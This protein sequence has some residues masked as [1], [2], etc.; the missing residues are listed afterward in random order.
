MLFAGVK[1]Y[2]NIP[3][4]LSYTDRKKAINCALPELPFCSEGSQDVPSNST[5]KLHKVKIF[6]SDNQTVRLNS[7]SHWCFTSE[8][9]LELV[10]DTQRL[11]AYN[12]ALD[13]TALDSFF[14]QQKQIKN[15]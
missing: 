14:A 12:S 13:K 9:W 3:P 5:L 1:F 8:F 11:D 10:F 15:L 7:Q 2:Q 6:E 4:H